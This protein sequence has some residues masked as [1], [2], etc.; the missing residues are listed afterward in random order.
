MK[1]PISLVIPVYNVEK[2]LNKCVDSALAQT[3]QNFEIILIDDGSTDNSGNICDEYA[4]KDNRITVYH[5]TNGGLSSARNFGVQHA[6]GNLIA[7]LDSDDYVSDIYLEY[8]YEL[9]EKYDADMVRTCYVMSYSD[10]SANPPKL[11]WKE[12]V[13]DTVEAL[14][15]ICYTSLSAVASLY[16]K[17]IVLRHPYPEGRLYEDMATTYRIVGECQ[18]IVFSDRPTY[19]YV[20]R[21]SSIMHRKIDRKNYDIFWAAQEQLKYIQENYPSAVTAAESRCVLAAASFFDCLFQSTSQEEKE[22]YRYAR[23]FSKPY[24]RDVIVDKNVSKNIRIKSA[25]MMMGYWPTKLFWKLL[26]ICKVF[27]SRSC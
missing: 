9:M 25:V 5:K 15:Q 26:G 22:Y 13:F 12:M 17:E 10:R 27:M 4:A 20:Q 2:Y 3:Y 23:D 19:F 8:M 11:E 6:N 16:K 1:P 7:F 24:I 14:K 21:N 18:R